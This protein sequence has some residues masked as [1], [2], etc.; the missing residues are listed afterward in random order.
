M[1]Q[2]ERNHTQKIKKPLKIVRLGIVIMVAILLL[3]LFAKQCYLVYIMGP[4][5]ADNVP[6]ENVPKW[7]IYGGK[8]RYDELYRMGTDHIREHLE[9]K[10][11]ESTKIAIDETHVMVD[12]Y[13][14]AEPIE[15]R[16]ESFFDDRWLQYNGV[17]MAK[18]TIDGKPC[19]AYVDLD[20]DEWIVYDTYQRDVIITAVT[21]YFDNLTDVKPIYNQ[22]WIDEYDL[23]WGKIDPNHPQYENMYG[24]CHNYF[25]GD[26]E[27]FLTNN[28]V[29]NN[30]NISV[31][32]NTEQ[33]LP[34]DEEF[35]KAIGKDN[36]AIYRISDKEIAKEYAESE[37]LEITDVWQHIDEAYFSRGTQEKFSMQ[38][39]WEYQNYLWTPKE[40]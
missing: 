10:Y 2:T 40:K 27:R 36:V 4:G 16:S 12:M 9:K 33:Q 15:Y 35:I 7:L 3:G 13:E 25:D 5:Y 6:F 23:Y 17:V 29:P 34:I 37:T 1:E 30:I 31:I 20:T 32:Y 19:V 24:A 21:E 22:V 28:E 14:I 11:S 38:W 18:C 26:V 8:A 39:L